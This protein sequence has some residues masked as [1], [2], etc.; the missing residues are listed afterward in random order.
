M[1]RVRTTNRLHS[2]FRKSEVLDL[3]FLNQVLHRASE[4][5]L[6]TFLQAVWQVHAASS[7][8]SGCSAARIALIVPLRAK[9]QWLQTFLAPRSGNLVGRNIGVRTR[10]VVIA[11]LRT[12]PSSCSRLQGISFGYSNNGRLRLRL[13]SPAPRGLLLRGDKKCGFTNTAS[14]FCL[15][16]T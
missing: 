14:L 12:G 10:K 13:R 15:F 1:D 16:K 11:V 6:P 3:T 9:L 7:S 2:C 5:Y 8:Q 4:Q